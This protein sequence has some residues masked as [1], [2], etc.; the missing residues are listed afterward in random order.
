MDTTVVGSG[1]DK[2]SGT[3]HLQ[4]H[5]VQWFR[6]GLVFKVHRLVYHSTLGLRV[7]KKKKKKKTAET[8]P[9]EQA[10]SFLRI[11]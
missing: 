10:M 5:P 9:R 11:C 1:A 4:Q 8:T 2:P 6:G 3:R 7:I